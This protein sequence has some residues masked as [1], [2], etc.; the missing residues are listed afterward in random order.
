MSFFLFF[1]R[2][3]KGCCSY[4]FQFLNTMRV[5]RIGVFFF[6]FLAC[7]FIYS[8]S[9]IIIFSQNLILFSYFQKK[10]SSYVFL[11][12]SSSHFYIFLVDFLFPFESRCLISCTN[13]DMFL[14]QNLGC[15][16]DKK[17]SQV[18]TPSQFEKKKFC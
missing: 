7:K 12:L 6:S 14:Q 3:E 8:G 11:S 17:H 5:A 15:A 2:I 10:N 9:I 1:L 16:R 13:I 18:L 4:C